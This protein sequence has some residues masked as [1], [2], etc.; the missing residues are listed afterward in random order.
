[1]SL[2]DK[3]SDHFVEMTYKEIKKENIE[4]DIIIESNICINCGFE[5]KRKFKFCVSCGNEL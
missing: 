1:M 2:S 5:N 4:T 3:I